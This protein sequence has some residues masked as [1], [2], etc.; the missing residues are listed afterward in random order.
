[1]LG[2]RS[3][4][5]SAEPSVDSLVAAGQV[6]SATHGYVLLE[7]AGAFGHE[8]RGREVIGSLAVNLIVALG[9]ER[10]A[11]QRSL[12]AALAARELS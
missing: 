8:D 11:A 1:V 6:L 12:G 3:N 10:E 7:I 9:D 2:H 4:P 5:L